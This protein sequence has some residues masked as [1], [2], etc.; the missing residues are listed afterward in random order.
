MDDIWGSYYLQKKIKNKNFIVFN[1]A[2]V[3]QERNNHNLV[4]DLKNE[5]LGYESTIKFNRENIND[6]IPQKTKDCIKTYTKLFK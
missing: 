6:Y 5:I 4:S 2:S 3:Y 1:N